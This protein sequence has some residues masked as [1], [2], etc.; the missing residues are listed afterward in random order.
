MELEV[1]PGKRHSVVIVGGAAFV[2]A[3]LTGR[4]ATH[5]VGVLRADEAIQGVL[6]RHRQLKCA[7]RQLAATR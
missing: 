2:L 4:N 5:D 6:A 1:G 7:K 3:D